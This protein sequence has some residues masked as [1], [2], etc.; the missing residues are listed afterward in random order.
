MAYYKSMCPL[1]CFDSC[2]WQVETSDG[3]I[4]KVSGDPDHP[5][6][7]GKVCP[8]AKRQIERMY[9]PDRVLFPLKKVGSGWQRVSWDDAFE[10][11]CNKLTN[12]AEESGTTAVLH[13]FDSGSN[14]MLNEL[15]R[16][17]FNAYGGVTSTHGSICWGAGKAAQTMDF[18]GCRAHRWDDVLNSKVVV[19]WG[20]NVAVT[21]RHLLPLLQDVKRKGGKVVVINPVRIQLPFE[22]DLFLPVQ[23]GADGILALAVGHVLCR[24]RWL[25]LSFISGHVDG[26]EAYLELIKDITPDKAASITGI[27]ADLIEKFAAIYSKGESASIFFGYGMQRYSNGGQTVR[28]IDTL[29]TITGN[30]GKRGGGANYSYSDYKSKMFGDI[31]GDELAVSTRRISYPRW[32]EEVLNL[33]SPPIRG[34]FVTR[35]NPVVQLPDTTKVKEA[36][37]KAEFVVT[38]DF[39]LTDTAEE[40]DL[41]LPCTTIF[42]AENIVANGMNQ[43]FAYTPKVVEPLGESRSD[44]WIFSELAKRMG[45]INRFG[46]FSTEQWMEELI[47]PLNKYEVNLSILKEN[48]IMENPVITDIAWEDKNFPTPSGKVNILTSN[49]SELNFLG[50]VGEIGDETVKNE[51]PLILLTPHSSERIHSQFHNLQLNDQ[52]RMPVL[53]HPETAI[54]HGFANGQNVI[55]ESPRGQVLGNVKLTEKVLPGV[56]LIESGWWIKFG[57]G[58]NFLTPNTESDIGITS[59]YYDCRCNVKRDI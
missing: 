45:L 6:T 28:A 24:E 40:S 38:V 39:A 42:E 4:V 10:L 36:F 49:F 18:G 22:P 13:N 37:K 14:G 48:G 33:D 26:F 55:V 35:S 41:V 58:V 44:A 51:F 50:S 19:L 12:I 43:Y 56:V 1:D 57:G 3:K 15:D 53:A 30:V 29:A 20:R 9:S 25:D 47:K 5:F 7:K 32:G 31:S 23:P 59:A 54:K 16:R 2:T 17:F 21:N 8:K 52:V 11:M 34:I 46:S 27:S